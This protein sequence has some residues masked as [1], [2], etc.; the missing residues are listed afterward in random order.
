MLRLSGTLATEKM[1][2][3]PPARTG[4]FAAVSRGTV[5]R[6]R[7]FAAVS[8][9]TAARSLDFAT[10]SLVIATVSRD[11]AVIS[12]V[13]VTMSHGTAARSFDITAMSCGTAAMSLDIAAMSRGIVTIPFGIA[14]IPPF[15]LAGTGNITTGKRATCERNA[16]FQPE[17][18]GSCLWRPLGI[19]NGL[20]GARGSQWTAIN[21]F[22]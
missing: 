20:G 17:R 5:A 9:G 4:D 1:P 3:A 7:G 15:P 21:T 22:S 6:S 10:M 18:V 11:I 8:F 19:A 2:G 16:R 13:T 12:L 14:T